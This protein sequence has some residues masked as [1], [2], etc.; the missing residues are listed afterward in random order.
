MTI[1]LSRIREAAAESIFHVHYDDLEGPRK[2]EECLK[3]AAT[4]LSPGCKKLNIGTVAEFGQLDQPSVPES[5][6]D[7]IRG[8]IFQTG[9]TVE[10]ENKICL[11]TFLMIGPPQPFDAEAFYENIEKYHVR[12]GQQIPENCRINSLTLV[13]AEGIDLSS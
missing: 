4:M 2:Y 11:V 10:F 3:D 7:Q 1:E 8:K 9:F 6:A 13:D 12:I 5:V